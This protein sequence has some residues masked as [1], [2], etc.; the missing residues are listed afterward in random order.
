MSMLLSNGRAET[1][2]SGFL[3]ISFKS[4]IKALKAVAEGEILLDWVGEPPAPGPSVFSAT[5]E[6][7]RK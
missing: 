6:A 5:D 2:G 4:C 7:R 1:N 3:T